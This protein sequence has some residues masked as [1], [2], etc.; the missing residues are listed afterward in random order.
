MKGEIRQ[1]KLDQQKSDQA[2]ERFEF[3]QARLA[4]EQAEKAA[5]RKARAEAAA[6]AQAAKKSL[7]ETARVDTQEKPLQERSA[8]PQLSQ[9]KHKQGDA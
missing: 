2:R 7:R 9:Q 3:R 1:Q 4:R 6:L 8:Q 5:K